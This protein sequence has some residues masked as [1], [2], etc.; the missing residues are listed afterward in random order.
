MLL[1][2]LQLSSANGPAECCLAVAKALKVLLKEAKKLQLDI[3]I[4]EEEQGAESNTLK[5]VL[6]SVEGD[7]AHHLAENWQG[8]IQWIC[9]SPY[10][11]NHRRKNWFIGGN[12]SEQQEKT[13][14]LTLRFEA[15]RSSGPGG[16]HANKTDSA[17]RATHIE[18][19]ISVKVQSER[20]Q[21]ANK[22]LAKM[23]IQHKL[24][25]LELEQIEVQKTMRHKAHQQI[26]RGEA[27]RSFE[28]ERFRE[29]TDST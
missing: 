19:G 17:I 14:S 23:L 16:Q 26:E 1:I 25:N 3:Q 7:N 22:R 20:S 12:F 10:R 9:Q 13:S 11:P 6:L 5:S 2:L 27:I 4:V 29:I 15:C 8:T 21:H 18:S 24:E 28:G